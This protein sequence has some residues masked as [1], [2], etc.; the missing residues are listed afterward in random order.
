MNT[1]S[2]ANP[3]PASSAVPADSVARPLNDRQERFC[4]HYSISGNATEAAREAGYSERSAYA[5]GSRLAHDPRV[6]D[7]IYRMRVSRAIQFGPVIAFTR[8][9]HLFQQAS[10]SGDY[11]AAASILTLQARLAGVESWTPPSAVAK[12]AQRGQARRG[13]GALGPKGPDPFDNLSESCGIVNV[14]P[15]S[16]GS[17][18]DEQ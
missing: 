7:R 12:A 5:Q 18:N 6:C 10:E 14:G 8:L 15:A 11:R 3:I 9:E 4:A 17:E 1:N 16:G 13:R 2:E